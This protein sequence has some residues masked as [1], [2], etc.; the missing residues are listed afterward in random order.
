M[1]GDICCSP[2]LLSCLGLR[3]VDSSVNEK[4][5]VGIIWMN[6]DGGE[7]E[8]VNMSTQWISFIN[9]SRANLML[10]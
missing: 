9:G 1:F 4:N 10:T 5:A 7:H 2:N 3:L 6:M 8:F